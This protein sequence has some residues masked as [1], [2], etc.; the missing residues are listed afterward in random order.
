VYLIKN[1]RSLLPLREKVR[2]RV[3][4]NNDLISLIPTLSLRKRELLE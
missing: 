4:K 3:F 2:M 1:K